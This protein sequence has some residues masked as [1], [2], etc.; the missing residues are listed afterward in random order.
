[1]KLPRYTQA[2]KLANGIVHYRFNPPQRLVD[3]GVV[4]RVELGRNFEEAKAQAKILN[5]QINAWRKEQAKIVVL[6]GSS[7]LS[8]LMD[9]YYKSSDF[10]MLKHKTKVDYQYFLSVLLESLGDCPIKKVSTRQAKL[11]YEDWV[12][13]GIH[14]ANH[15]AT[16]SSRLYRYAIDMEYTEFNPFSSIRRKSPRQRKVMWSKEQVIKFL[17][18][19]YSDFSTR[20]IGLIVQMTYE[21]CQRLGDMR[22]LEW[23]MFD[24]DNRRLNLEQSKRRAQVSLPISNDLYPMLLD[25]RD[26]FGFQKYVAPRPRPREGQFHPYTLEGMSTMGRVVMEKAGLPKDLRLM[27]LRR[28]GTTE[29]IE[30][31]VGMA[32]I[33]SVT[34]HNNPQSVK[35]YMKNTYTSANYA[36]TE[37]AKHD[38]STSKCRTGK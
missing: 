24:F 6:T 16:V 37:R 3:T 18:E 31:G 22:L 36:L 5:K 25:Q 12:G 27:D 23:D 2:R 4:E 38:T 32:Q 15:V 20:N 1:M 13:R 35:P 7:T 29:M 11:A 34:G 21:W 14:F 8:M 28:T 10:N 9:V 19:A 17:D 30:A 33:M 26:D